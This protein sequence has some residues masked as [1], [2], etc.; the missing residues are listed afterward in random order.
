MTRSLLFSFKS[1][2]NW[3]N[4]AAGTFASVAESDD[5]LEYVF[6]Q[7]RKEAY[8]RLKEYISKRSIEL[9]LYAAPYHDSVDK[10]VSN[11]YT[12]DEG[13]DFTGG[14]SNQFLD[15]RSMPL[16]DEHFTDYLHTNIHAARSIN[17][18]VDKSLK[19]LIRCDTK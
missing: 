14:G 4:R 13:F 11:P 16:S 7:S 2:Q 5:K 3:I 18:E 19:E 15:F 1:D 8:F 9:I 12:W 6:D 10:L 17:K